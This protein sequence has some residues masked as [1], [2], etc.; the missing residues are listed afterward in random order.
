[1]LKELD[2]C[3][4]KKDSLSTPE[5]LSKP[6]KMPTQQSNQETSRDCDGTK[7]ILDMSCILI[8]N[9]R[10]P[11]KIVF[12]PVTV[13]YK[14]ANYSSFCPNVESSLLIG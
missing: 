11:S 1:M 13:E 14:M 5:D 10:K 9:F 12:L 7:S 3:D 8:T 4:R 6:E 2:T